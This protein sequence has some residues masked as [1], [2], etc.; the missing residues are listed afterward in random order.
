MKIPPLQ[1]KQVG[2]LQ[3]LMAFQDFQETAPLDL[4]HHCWKNPTLVRATV[5]L[6]P[7]VGPFPFLGVMLRCDSLGIYLA[8]QLCTPYNYVVGK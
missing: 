7:C 3:N 8:L 4:D 5:F 6:C 2:V 1:N